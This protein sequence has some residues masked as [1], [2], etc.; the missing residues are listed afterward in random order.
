MRRAT[1]SCW[2]KADLASS[3]ELESVARARNATIYA[4]ILSVERGGATTGLNQWPP[5]AEP[6]A[7]LMTRALAGAGVDA[8]AIDVVYASANSTDGWIAWR[9]KR[10]R[11]YSA[12]AGR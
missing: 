3:L 2:A 4:E 1:A 6:L 12:A 10:S 7:R 8:D 5:S 9:R 11:T